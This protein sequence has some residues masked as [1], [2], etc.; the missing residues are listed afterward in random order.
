M[1]HVFATDTL[2]VSHPK[3]G[4]GIGISIGEHWRADDP[5]V[6][7]YPQFFTDDA[8]Y[9]L[10]SSVPLG[11]DGHPTDGATSE[12]TAA[13]TETTSAAPGEKRSRK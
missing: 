7:A 12:R 8:R 11:D 1:D 5:I 4:I 3:T 10:R 2:V 13:A 9:G 6:E